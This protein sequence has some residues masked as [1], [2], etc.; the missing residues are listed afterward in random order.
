M[1][2][3]FILIVLMFAGIWLFSKIILY[4]W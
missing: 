1:N 3:S 4:C 2:R